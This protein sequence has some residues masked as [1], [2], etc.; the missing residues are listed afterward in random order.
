MTLSKF[1][2]MM[3]DTKGEEFDDL[4]IAAYTIGYDPNDDDEGNGMIMH[5][6]VGFALGLLWRK[7]NAN[8][9]DIEKV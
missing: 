3:R 6:M 5:M 9:S 8:K 7:N 1:I 2:R 4:C